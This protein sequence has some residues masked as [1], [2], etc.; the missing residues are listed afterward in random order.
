MDVDS[1]QVSDAMKDLLKVVDADDDGIVDDVNARDAL[2]ILSSM[3]ARILGPKNLQRRMEQSHSE[4]LRRARTL[5]S[6]SL[7]STTRNKPNALNP[8]PE[9]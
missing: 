9:H 5:P 3:K 8:T 7:D 4:I 1:L 6:H 2:R